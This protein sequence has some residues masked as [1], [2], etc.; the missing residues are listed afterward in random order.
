[1][2]EVLTDTVTSRDGTPVRFRRL[3]SGPGLLMV[4]GAMCSGRSHLELAS[5]LAQEHTV[6]LPDRREHGADG[7]TR[8]RSGR[9]TEQEVDDLE[10][11]AVATGARQA[12]GLSSGA[13]ALMETALAR[14]GLLDRLALYEPVL[15]SDVA[16]TRRMREQLDRDVAAGDVR[17]AL[18]TG[19][20]GVQAGPAWLR[21]LPRPLLKSMVGLGLRAEARK[22]SGEYTPM[23][24]LAIA[25]R[26]D[27]GLV[28][29]ACEAGSERFAALTGEVLLLG[30]ERSPAFLSEVL[31]RL[32]RLLP[33]AQRVTFPG[34][35]H[36]A[37]C[38]AAQRGTPDL[39]ARTLQPFFA[40]PVG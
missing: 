23:R 6:Y 33:A 32:E 4:H 37:S 31:D 21:N 22:G 8:Y 39:V 3:G 10:A 20:R 35:G 36:E 18:V 30:G 9:I 1:M 26:G 27:F 15:L 5:A 11:L 38:D 7:D 24:Q 34:V 2:T 25:L 17:G 28:A 16:G 13:L 29:E 40:R 14:P 19:W 12:F